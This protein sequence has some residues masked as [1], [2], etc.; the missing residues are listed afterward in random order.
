HAA[1]WLASHDIPAAKLADVD[2]QPQVLNGNVVTYWQYIDGREATADELPMLG[3]VLRNLHSLPAP[4]Q[5]TLEPVQDVLR[6]V[7]PRLT[8]SPIADDDKPPL[9]SP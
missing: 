7:E 5:F 4:T 9:L 1:D 3:G 6:K 8:A 2:G